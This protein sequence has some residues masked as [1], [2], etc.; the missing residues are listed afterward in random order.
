MNNSKKYDFII[1]GMGCAGL[2]L[3]IQL[4][5]SKIKFDKVLLIDSD[6]KNK[7]D[8][9]WCFWT[10]EKNNWFD[11]I[12]HKKWNSFTFKSNNYHQTFNLSPYSYFMLRG[13]DFYSY[14]LSEIKKDLRFEI[15]NEHI[16]EIGS[17]KEVAFLNTQTHSYQSNYLFNS[18]FRNLKIK[19]KDVNYVQHFKGWLVETDE[20]TFDEENPI[21][22]DFNVN[23]YHDCRFVYV[24]PISK[25]KA[26]I[27]YTGFSA[28]SMTDENYDKELH[29]YLKNN[30]KITVFKILET[31]KGI[32]PMTEGEFINPYGLRVVNIGTSGSSS[33]PSSGY[34]FY[35]IQKNIINIISQLEKKYE[36][37]K[38]PKR[39][40]RYLFY[41]KILLDV[42]NKKEILPNKVFK[43]LFNKNNILNLLA[44]LNEEASLLQDLKIMNSVNKRIFIISALRK[45]IRAK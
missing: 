2:S 44:F 41:D 18:A 23:Q 7:N 3:A 43:D 19:K 16:K 38:T 9:T 40:R 35:F 11:D 34:T 10:K 17:K 27:E 8:R 1:A 37:I 42:L 6:L 32:I 29:S 21:F 26:L 39:N 30:L 4:I 25:F 28:E 33:K 12:A 13:I 24:I 15:V 36:I 45:L 22:M 20:A 5:H 31:E 14:C